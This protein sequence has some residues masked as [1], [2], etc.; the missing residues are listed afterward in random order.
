MWR[1]HQVL[2]RSRQSERLLAQAQHMAMMGSWEKHLG[3]G[4]F[5]VSEQ[6]A[7]LFGNVESDCGKAF[8]F[9]LDTV[10]AEDRAGLIRTMDQVGATGKPATL[11]HHV[12][13]RNGFS[14]TVR[15]DLDIVGLR[16]G[17]AARGR[18]TPPSK[19]GRASC[20]ERV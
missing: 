9:F 12:G 3:S 14:R 17:V 19:I 18:A 20:R 15:H 2:F 4:K 8:Q 1:T 11:T 5:T 7:R 16:A 13:K 6:F 10:P